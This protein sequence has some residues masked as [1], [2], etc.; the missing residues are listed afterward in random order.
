[1]YTLYNL[2][3][4]RVNRFDSELWLLSMQSCPRFPPGSPEV[5]WLDECVNVCV[6]GVP[7]ESPIRGVFMTRSYCSG[8][9]AS[10]STGP[11]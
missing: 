2:H 1:M 7:C 3:S 8:T 5:D 4:F 6:C 11:G 9:K 10:D